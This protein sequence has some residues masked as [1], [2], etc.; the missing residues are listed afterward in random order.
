[1][2]H[3][4]PVAHDHPQALA[5]LHGRGGGLAVGE[6]APFIRHHLPAQVDADFSVWCALGQ[7]CTVCWLQGGQKQSGRRQLGE[8]DIGVGGLAAGG[9]DDGEGAVVLL[10]R[11]S[12]TTAGAA[13]SAANLP[14]TDHL[15]GSRSGKSA[16]VIA[17]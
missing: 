5:L 14:I 7:E 15:L 9:A 10:R 3:H 13:A 16:T 12:S 2:G 6:N 8:V 1:M 11:V 4:G 17:N